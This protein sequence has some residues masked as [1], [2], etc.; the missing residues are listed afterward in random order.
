MSPSRWEIDETINF[1][2]F[3][4]RSQIN[5]PRFLRHFGTL[6]PN[7]KNETTCRAY[8]ACCN[9]RH[10]YIGEVNVVTRR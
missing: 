4:I 9:S 5:L 6:V 2:N 8:E 3:A 10:L 7:E 1:R